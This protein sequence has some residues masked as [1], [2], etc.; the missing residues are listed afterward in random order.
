VAKG[1]EKLLGKMFCRWV[2]KSA[3][4]GLISSGSVWFVDKDDVQ[5]D[6]SVE[7]RMLAEKMLLPAAWYFFHIVYFGDF[8]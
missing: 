7:H 4:K 2:K 6:G 1:V 3:R 5:V 8:I